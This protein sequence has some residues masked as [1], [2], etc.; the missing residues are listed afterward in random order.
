MQTSP[1]PWSNDYIQDEK[2]NQWAKFCTWVE[3]SPV[4]ETGDR[5][6]RAEKDLGILVNGKLARTQQGEAAAQRVN[7]GIVGVAGCLTLI[8]LT[9][10]VWNPVRRYKQYKLSVLSYLRHQRVF[11][12]G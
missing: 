9:C 10:L 5:S 2:Q 3:Q 12:G 7:D 4:S 1:R 8:N 6:L 11:F